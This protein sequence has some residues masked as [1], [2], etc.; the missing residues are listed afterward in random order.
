MERHHS[1]SDVD[2]CLVASSLQLE[3]LLLLSARL[4]D[5]LLPWRFDLQLQQRIDYPR[6]AGAHRAGWG[7]LAPFTGCNQTIGSSRSESLALPLLGDPPRKNWRDGEFIRA[8][9]NASASS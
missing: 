2:L 8:K 6:L 4:D 3:D 7:G 9:N 1:G 5:L